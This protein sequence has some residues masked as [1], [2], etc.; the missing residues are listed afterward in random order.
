MGPDRLLTR[1]ARSSSQSPVYAGMRVE[2]KGG[3]RCLVAFLVAGP[4]GGADIF[5]AVQGEGDL[6][7]ERCRAETGHLETGLV[8]L[9]YPGFSGL[10]TW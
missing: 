10:I 5:L 7:G 4:D 1:W 2:S 3:V 6:L 9:A 8:A